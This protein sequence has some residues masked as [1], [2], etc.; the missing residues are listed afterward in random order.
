MG[1]AKRIAAPRPHPELVK[2]GQHP[3]VMAEPLVIIVCPT[4]E[5]GVQIFNEARKFCYR[6]M[7]RPAVIY[8]GA[9]VPDQIQSLKYGCDIL[10]CT[11]GRM[12]DMMQRPHVLSLRRVRHVVI[13]EADEML[14]DSW[15]DNLNTILSG[16]GKFIP[17]MAGNLVIS[18]LTVALDQEEGNIKY[19]LFSAT[20]PPRLKKL[21]EDYLAANHVRIE[22]GRAGSSH[23]N[24]RQDVV[25][26][27]DSMKRVALLDYLMSLEP[28]RC[29][30]FVNHKQAADEIDDFIFGNKLPCTS[31]HAD[32]TQREREDALRNFRKGT[33]PIMVTTG[34]SARGI[35][36]RNVKYVINYDL[37][38]VD[39]GGIEEYVHRIGMSIYSP[40][41]FTG[42]SR[43]TVLTYL[44]RSYRPYR[45]RW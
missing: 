30:V 33:T 40:V 2:S 27:D 7:L 21:A 20:F 24:V 28:G 32:R 13:D 41:L 36:V 10:V 35:D 1:K 9:K 29:I 42:T 23:E 11:P 43:H 17:S 39:H 6:T 25:W 3:G 15:S 16:G 14:T 34:I 12:V 37:P 19:M 38:S 18:I 4:R 45:S 44:A 26:V 8:G 5:L 31:M 22:V